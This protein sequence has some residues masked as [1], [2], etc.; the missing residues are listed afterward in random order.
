MREKGRTDEW[1]RHE[2]APVLMISIR[3]NQFRIIEAYFDGSKLVVR[4]SG[5]IPMELTDSPQKQQ[6][7]INT[8]LRWLVATP[9]GETLT[10]PRASAEKTLV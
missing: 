2:V 9:V 1:M 8:L 7:T 3:M 10:F 4:F 5:P 6:K